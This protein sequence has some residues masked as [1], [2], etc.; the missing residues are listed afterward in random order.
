MSSQISSSQYTTTNQS[1]RNLHIKISLLDFNFFTVNNIEGN[2]LDGNISVDA[3]SD[4]RRSGNLSFIVTNSSF[5]I[6]SGGQIWLDKYVKIEVGVEDMRTQEIAWS[7]LGI[8]LINQPTYDY[9]AITK[10]M[11]FQCVDLMTKM[12]GARNGYI[13]GIGAEG[14][15]L[16]PVGSNVKEAIV[17]IVKKCGF[18]RYYISECINDDGEIQPVPYDMQ[19]Q[20]G[21]TWYNILAELRDIIPN[22]QMYFD[23]D[24][25]FRY[26][27]IPSGEN[28]PVMITDDLWK[29]NVVQEVLHV[30]FEDVKNVVE[31]WGRVHETE[32][33][34][35]SSV[36]VVNGNIIEPTWAGISVLED[37]MIVALSLPTAVQDANG[38]Y[39]DFLSQ[40]LI[41]K[42]FGDN[43]ITELPADEY[44][45]FYYDPSGYWIYLGGAQAYAVWKD[46]NPDSPFYIGSTIGE[47]PI[48]LSGNEYDNIMSNDL[49]L[50]RAKY[51]IYRRCRLNDTIDLTTLPVYWADVNWKISY[52]PLSGDRETEEYMVQSINIPLNI[53]STQ[54]WNLSKFY[55]FY[56]V[57]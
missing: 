10:K 28:D 12:T 47:I 27:K 36:T 18:N 37:Y 39:I 8:F 23:I 24:G 43:T 29:N 9:D 25:V 14:F 4:I 32:H 20:Q 22:Y 11:S 6:Q 15:V 21:T 30:N 33:F 52:T 1:L 16:I 13:T 54:S 7:N 42:D 19:F 55:P 5:N 50:E 46:F 2:V 40:T 48:V 31:I 56:P 45:A 51:E 35:D 49:A 34:S 38:I 41:I 26:E 3:T 53:S 44:L 57:I 17:D